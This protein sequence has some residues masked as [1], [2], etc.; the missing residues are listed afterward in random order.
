MTTEYQRRAA[1]DAA[2]ASCEGGCPG[3]FC[4]A[5][6]AASPGMCVH[7]VAAHTTGP[8]GACWE[9]PVGSTEYRW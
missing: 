9:F 8:D 7:C 3:C 5:W 1:A 4:E 6:T 2:M